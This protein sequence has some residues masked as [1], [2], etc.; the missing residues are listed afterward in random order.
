M[1]TASLE[2]INLD[3]ENFTNTGQ[4]EANQKNI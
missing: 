3:E 2:Y 4:G 1:Q